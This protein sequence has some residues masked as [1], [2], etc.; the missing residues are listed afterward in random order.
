MPGPQRCERFG[1]DKVGIVHV[2]ERC[3]RQAYLAGVDRESGKDVSFQNEWIRRRMKALASVVAIRRLRVFPGRRLEEHLAK[4]TK[5]DQVG[6]CLRQ[7]LTAR[8]Q[9]CPVP[10]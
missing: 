2:V 9:K 6:I 3:V 4:P 5:S 7:L 8:F 10:V 1:P